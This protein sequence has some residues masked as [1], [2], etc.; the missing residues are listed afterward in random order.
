LLE[1]VAKTGLVA[2]EEELES[3]PAAD[4]RRSPAIG[5]ELRVFAARSYS[6]DQLTQPA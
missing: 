1:N 2:A 6:A 4:F 3:R 5:I